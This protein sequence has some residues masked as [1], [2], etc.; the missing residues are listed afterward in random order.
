MFGRPHP[1][2]R[3]ILLPIAWQVVARSGGDSEYHEVQYFVAVPGSKVEGKEIG[4]P[5]DELEGSVVL[6]IMSMETVRK[7]ALS[8]AQ[9]YLD[10]LSAEQL[11]QTDASR[12][13]FH[14]IVLE[15]AD[16]QEVR[17]LLLAEEYGDAWS[18]IHDH[19]LQKKLR[20]LTGIVAKLREFNHVFTDVPLVR[21]RMR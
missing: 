12:I 6:Q 21:G 14:P 15:L 11:Q 16:E 7:F 2:L 20:S 13:F 8:R 5:I 18:F 4:I 9:R 3:C 19:T 1:Q 17:A 10:K